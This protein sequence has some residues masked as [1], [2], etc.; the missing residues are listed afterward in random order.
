MTNDERMTKHLPSLGLS[1]SLKLPPSIFTAR[2]DDVTSPRDKRLLRK[3]SRAGGEPRRM[4]TEDSDSWE[5]KDQ[6]SEIRNQVAL[7][8]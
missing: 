2:P 4:E 5:G 6:K 8:T 1:Y 7:R 3:L